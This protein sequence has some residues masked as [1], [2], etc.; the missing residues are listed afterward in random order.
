MEKV[1]MIKIHNMNI[2][3]YILMFSSTLTGCQMMFEQ[4]V[5]DQHLT[6]QTNRTE[7]IAPLSVSFDITN[8][9][10]ADEDMLMLGEFM[11]DF[12]DGSDPYNV[13]KGYCPSHVYRKP[14]KYTAT[15]T[16]YID[17]QV[18]TKSVKIKVSEF[19]GE[20]YYISNDGADIPGNGS[21]SNPFATPAYAFNNYTASKCT[22]SIEARRCFLSRYL[23]PFWLI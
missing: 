8:T 1:I 12:G 2:L 23:Y 11:W 4:V 10:F 14:G 21:I 20:T 17:D 13:G 5:Q 19:S 18:I 9:E 22:F 16:G 15:V 7:G 3:F 6:L